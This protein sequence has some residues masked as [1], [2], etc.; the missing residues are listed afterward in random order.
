MSLSDLVVN[1][2][3]RENSLLEILEVYRNIFIFDLCSFF[4]F[5]MGIFC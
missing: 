4:F 3:A 1:V 5:V 2:V